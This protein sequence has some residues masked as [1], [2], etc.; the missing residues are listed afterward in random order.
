M[1]L[2]A[3]FRDMQTLHY[4]VAH[5]FPEVVGRSRIKIWDAGCASG[6]E[7]FTLAMICREHLGEFAFRNVVI[8]ATDHEES[9]FPQFRE[10]ISQGVYP[11]LV[12]KTTPRPDLMRKFSRRVRLGYVQVDE[13]IRARVRYE[14]HDLLSFREVASDFCLVVCKNVLLH[15]QPAER[16]EVVR[17]FH[18]A[19]VPGGYLAFDQAQRVPPE[20]EG[21]FDNIAEG[22]FLYRKRA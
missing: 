22:G 11:D 10:M 18:R 12:L 9:D 17:M 14:R 7:P 19:L 3:F 5:V 2:T 20:T 8:H 15:F 4:I 21:L 16:I 13:E 1:A 6:E